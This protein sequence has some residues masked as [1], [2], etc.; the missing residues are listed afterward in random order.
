MNMKEDKKNLKEVN[1][2]VFI[3]FRELQQVNIDL[4]QKKKK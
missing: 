3:E 4:I 1:N 2:N